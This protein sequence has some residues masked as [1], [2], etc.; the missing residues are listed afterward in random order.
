MLNFEQLGTVCLEVNSLP[1]IGGL[2]ECGIAE[3]GEMA[4]ITS[5]ADVRVVRFSDLQSRPEFASVLRQG[6][7]ITASDM[8]PV[9]MSLT[10]EISDFVNT[11][12]TRVDFDIISQ[13]DM[14][15]RVVTSQSGNV[16]TTV[17]AKIIDFNTSVNTPYSSHDTKIFG[18][19]LV[20]PEQNTGYAVFSPRWPPTIQQ[21]PASIL[22]IMQ[23]FELVQQ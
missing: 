11:M 9:Y 8:L 21:I 18:L 12:D 10:K 23:S 16:V 13:Q 15:V 17:P 3:A 14:N 19:F 22:Q 6:K 5:S 7:N 20:D 4:S 1:A 2:A